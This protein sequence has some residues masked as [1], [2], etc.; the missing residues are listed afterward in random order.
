VRSDKAVPHGGD[1]LFC[2]ILICAEYSIEETVWI[3][4]YDG[5]Y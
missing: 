2:D 1:G 3:R 5:E 4:Y